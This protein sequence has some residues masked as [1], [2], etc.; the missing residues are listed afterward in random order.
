[1]RVIARILK[2]I[3]DELEEDS[4]KCVNDKLDE[5]KDNHLAHLQTELI[6]LTGRVGSIEGKLSLLLGAISLVFMAVA[7]PILIN[8]IRG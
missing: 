1:M 6:K 3:L 7:A 8:Y 2:A 4:P 5:I